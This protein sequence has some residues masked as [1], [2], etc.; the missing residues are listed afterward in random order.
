MMIK[1]IT[2]SRARCLA[3]FR[4][5]AGIRSGADLEAGRVER[6]GFIFQL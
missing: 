4:L 5:K 1:K 2:W 6:S 3:I